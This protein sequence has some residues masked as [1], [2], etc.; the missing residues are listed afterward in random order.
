MLYYDVLADICSQLGDP[1]MDLYQE[2]AKD[3][4]A[5][6]ISGFI[7]AGQF[8]P[9]DIPGYVKL[10]TN[11]GFTAGVYDA[12]GLKLWKILA[13]YPNPS[14]AMD[15]TVTV[16]GPSELSMMGMNTDLRPQ[17]SDV[18]L[19]RVGSSIY[20]L[21]SSD[22]PVFTLASDTLHMQYI[23]D[24]DASVWDDT[25]T[26][27]TDFQSTTATYYFSFAFTRRCI[28]QA[29]QTLKQEDGG[30]A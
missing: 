10:K 24:I 21:T 16:I 29:V 6:A 20:G 11:L 4:F 5:R 12:K 28:S 7:E 15:V 19:Y 18:F 17:N 8:T 14:V 23:E 13:I 22:S 25:A 1:D 26:T 9:D 30:R 2:R 27:G 3:H